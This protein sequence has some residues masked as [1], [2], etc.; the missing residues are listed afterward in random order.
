[1]LEQEI[2]S[3][4]KYT[5]DR[6]GNPSPYYYEVPEDFIVPAAYFPTPEISTRGETFRTYAMDYTWFIKFFHNSTQEA[7][8][9]ALKALTAI[10]GSRNLIPLISTEGEQTGEKLRINDPSLNTIDSGAV[11]LQLNW[12]SRRPYDGNDVEKM[13]L[14]HIEGW[15][16]PD[17]YMQKVIPAAF[18]EAIEQITQDYPDIRYAGQSPEN[19]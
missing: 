19:P 16:N 8:A 5:L 6:A 7:Y 4:I 17:I 2:A 3:I 11:Q 12:T 9:L 18:S 10:K 13:Q 14:Y 15:N 1:M